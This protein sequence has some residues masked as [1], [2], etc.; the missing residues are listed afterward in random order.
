MGAKLESLGI[1]WRPME[2]EQKLVGPKGKGK[3][4]SLQN[5][6]R[7]PS[8][9]SQ[10][11]ESLCS[12]DGVMPTL[13][14]ARIPPSTKDTKKI[15]DACATCTIQCPIAPWHQGNEE[16]PGCRASDGSLG[17]LVPPGPQLRPK[18]LSW[19][20]GGSI[21]RPGY[22]KLS[23]ASRRNVVSSAMFP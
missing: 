19:C 4:A 3:G 2:N 20:P 13:P 12:R 1:T 10:A 8:R 9:A 6:V 5:V 7:I 16:V 21:R 18:Q 17:T 11:P 22:K 23:S 15:Q 14:Q